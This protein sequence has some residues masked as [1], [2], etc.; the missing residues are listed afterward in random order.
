MGL[1]SNVGRGE[2][3]ILVGRV[4]PIKNCHACNSRGGLSRCSS[5]SRAFYRGALC[6]SRIVVACRWNVAFFFIVYGDQVLRNVG[7]I[8]WFFH[9]GD[10]FRVGRRRQGRFMRPFFVYRGLLKLKIMFTG[11]VTSVGRIC[12]RFTSS[13]VKVYRGVSF[14]CRSNVV[15]V[16]NDLQRSLPIR[17]IIR[18][19]VIFLWVISGVFGCNCQGFVPFLV[20]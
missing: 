18:D 7:R 2:C 10:V 9:S 5:I 4:L 14:H 8:F 20:Y 16:Y 13:E 17:Q 3:L 15:C 6:P 12:T 1:Y 11:L 19:R